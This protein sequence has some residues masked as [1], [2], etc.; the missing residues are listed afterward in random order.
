VDTPIR[1]EPAFSSYSV[2]KAA[3]YSRYV[4]FHSLDFSSEQAIRSPPEGFAEFRDQLVNFFFSHM[5]F[6]AAKLEWLRAHNEGEIFVSP[7]GG[8]SIAI[9]GKSLE[10]LKDLYRELSH[11]DFAR[12]GDGGFDPTRRIWYDE[13]D[14]EMMKRRSAVVP[15][16]RFE[17]ETLDMFPHLHSAHANITPQTHPV[18]PNLPHWAGNPLVLMFALCFIFGILHAFVVWMIGLED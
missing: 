13:C 1:C 5:D 15:L 18:M 17:A 10:K 9:Y 11:E 3:P 12:T 16:G 6:Y 2:S 4:E 14:P 7:F 8:S